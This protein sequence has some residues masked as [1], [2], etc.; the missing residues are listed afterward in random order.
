MLP[1]ATLITVNSY[2]PVWPETKPFQ[3]LR[4]FS[5]TTSLSAKTQHFWDNQLH[6]RQSSVDENLWLLKCLVNKML[7]WEMRSSGRDVTL[8]PIMWLTGVRHVTLI[9]SKWTMTSGTVG[10]FKQIYKR[11]FVLLISTSAEV[12][13]CVFVCE[14]ERE[15]EII[16]LDGCQ[17]ASDDNS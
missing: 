6:H 10:H 3:F 9:R 5:D 12:C 14:R 7:F 16:N 11:E 8:L 15:T 13:V 1:H 2:E 17:A 4:L